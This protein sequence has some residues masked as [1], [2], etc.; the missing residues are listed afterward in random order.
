MADEPV[1]VIPNPVIDEHPDIDVKDAYEEQR[2]AVRE[3]VRL[4]SRNGPYRCDLGE[5]KLTFYCCCEKCCGKAADDPAYGITASG[6]RACEGIT[7]AVDPDVI[8]LG[9]EVYI[10]GYGKYIA[11]DTGKEIVG[12]VI[13]I[14][15][16]DHEQCLQVGVQRANVFVIVD[17]IDID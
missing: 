1:I 4:E 15:L 16:E 14:F 7:I 13:D 5:F 11:E 17:E 6:A 10:E 12:N 8:P 9:T 2:A 3:P